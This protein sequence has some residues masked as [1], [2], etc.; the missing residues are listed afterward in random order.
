MSYQTPFIEALPHP[1]GT[2]GACDVELPTLNCYDTHVP[3]LTTPEN[4][5]Q[6]HPSD[7]RFIVIPYSEYLCTCLSPS[8][9]LFPR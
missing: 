4:S 1:Q 5:P 3:S 6:N 2:N 9:T 8:Q 7:N